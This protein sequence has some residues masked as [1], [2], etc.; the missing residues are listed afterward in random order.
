M[1]LW[2]L[3]LVMLDVQA[4]F[5]HTPLINCEC[6]VPPSA[7]RIWFWVYYNKIPIYLIS[8][9]LKGGYILQRALT[10]YPTA[11][12]TPKGLR[13]WTL[14]SALTK[15]PHSLCASYSPLCGDLITI[16][17]KPCSIYLRGTLTYGPWTCLFLDG[18]LRKAG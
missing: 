11:S 7:D 13:H 14:A 15:R 10:P 2:N 5:R 17:P 16:Y 3:S 4:V 12:P 8:Y 1:R 6:R 9:V 18:C